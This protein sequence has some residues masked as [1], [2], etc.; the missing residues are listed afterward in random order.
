MPD[1]THILNAIEDGDPSAAEEFLPLIYYAVPKLRAARSQGKSDSSG[2]PYRV[3]FKSF[4]PGED[5]KSSA[6]DVTFRR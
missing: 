6:R 2:I 4:A 3:L 1:V 5:R